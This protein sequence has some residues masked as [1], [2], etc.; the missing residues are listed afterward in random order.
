M[1]LF[2][3]PESPTPTFADLVGEDKRYKTPEDAAK[4]ILEKD[5]FIEQLKS[6]TAQLRTEITARPAVDKSQEILDRLEALRTTPVTPQ[7]AAP[8]LERT[9]VKGLSLDDVE[10]VL[11]ERERKAR[12]E[13]NILKVK[14]TLQKELGDKYGQALKTMAET[15]GL[16]EKALNDL[17]AANPQLVLNLMQ[18]TAKPEQFVTP[19]DPSVS[20]GFT[21]TAGGPQKLTYYEKLKATDKTKYFST[22]VQQQMYKDGMTLK[23]AFY[24]K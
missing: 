7:Q 13:S 4:A 16:T 23:E 12:A 22:A 6:E 3:T 18:V 21:P 19:P 11:A 8:P 9:E 5:R 24:D 15:N 10:R 14:D 1:S 20:P 2:E 17:A